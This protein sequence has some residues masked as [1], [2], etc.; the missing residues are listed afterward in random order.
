MGRRV[1]APDMNS[2]LTGSVAE[3]RADRLS[4]C[5]NSPRTVRINTA[6]LFS[7]E[8]RPAFFQDS[9]LRFNQ[10][11]VLSA[12]RINPDSLLLD[13]LWVR[14]D[15]LG[16]ASSQKHRLASPYI[17]FRRSEFRPVL[18]PDHRCGLWLR[19]DTTRRTLD[20]LSAVARARSTGQK[21][22]EVRND[23]V[24]EILWRRARERRRKWPPEAQRAEH[25]EEF[26][27]NTG[28][29]IFEKGARACYDPQADE[30]HIP[31]FVLFKKADYFYST[32]GH[33]AIHNA[34]HR[35]MPR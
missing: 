24:L 20:H 13:L 3:A 30:I 12:P 26:F 22:R 7:V 23:R 17:F 5:P 21:R 6:R 10:P 33:E 1:P 8:V 28:I 19:A 29:K 31:P 25:A 32:L 4:S 27:R 9:C 16:R 14:R 15:H 35:V 2:R 34:A 18:A 11:V